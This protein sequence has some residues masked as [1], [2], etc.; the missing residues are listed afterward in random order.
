MLRLKAQIQAGAEF[1]N[2]A[3]Y[4]SDDAGSA[5]T[6]GDLGWVRKGQMVP[7]FEKTLFSMEEGQ[8]SEPVV[9]NFG[10]HIIKLNEVSSVADPEEQMRSIAYNNLMSQKMDQYYPAFLSKLM[11]TAYIKYL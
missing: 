1:G 9:T 4:Y 5:A 10:V 2:V 7:N 11:G 8:V 6:G 3:K